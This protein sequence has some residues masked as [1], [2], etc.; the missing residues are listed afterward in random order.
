MRKSPTTAINFTLPGLVKV[1]LE[2]YNINGQLVNTLIDAHLDVGYHSVTW[3][4]SNYSSG[5]Y[6][7]KMI[8]G[9]F[10]QTQKLMLIK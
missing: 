2:V 9:D 6:F 1:K 8:S 5:I 10:V 7:V 3:D 4:G